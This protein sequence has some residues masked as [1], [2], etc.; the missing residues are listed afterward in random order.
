M[1]GND[2]IKE[3]KSEKAVVRIIAQEPPEKD[4]L[5][6]ACKKFMEAVEAER[7]AR[8]AEEVERSA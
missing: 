6:H 8:P 4:G 3:Y 2:I 1:N 7:A 5:I